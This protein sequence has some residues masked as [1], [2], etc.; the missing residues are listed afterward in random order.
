MD[1]WILNAVSGHSGGTF[2]KLLGRIWW[3]K[4]AKVNRKGSRHWFV[5]CWHAN[6]GKLAVNK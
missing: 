5:I 1:S 3:G 4:S 2:S 6:N